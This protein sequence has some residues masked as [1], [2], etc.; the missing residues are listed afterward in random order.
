[1]TPQPIEPSAYNALPPDLALQRMVG[2]ADA[3]AFLGVSLPHFRR[4]YRDGRVPPPIKLS[5]RVLRWKVSTLIALN[6]TGKWEA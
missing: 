5:E 2:P 4:M 1:M 6:T 3:A